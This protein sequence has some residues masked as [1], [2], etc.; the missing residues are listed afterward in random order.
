MRKTKP[1]HLFDTAG[2][3]RKVLWI[4]HAFCA[5]LLIIDAL[6]HRHGLHSWEAIW[7]FYAIYGFV[8]CVS[9]AF[10]AR[11]LRKLVM[12]SERYYGDG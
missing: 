6:Y 3:T 10:V 2:N 1:R 8:A 7:G 12:V 5:G 4:F 9:L 11:Q